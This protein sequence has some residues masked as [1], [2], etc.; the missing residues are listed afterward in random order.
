MISIIIPVYNRHD[1][2]LVA[3]N[4]IANQTYTDIEVILVDDGSSPPLKLDASQ[5]PFSCT[6]L[7]QKN[8]GAPV[9][10]N[11]GFEASAGD[12]V[13]FWDA[14]MI[15]EPHMLET[16]YAKLQAHRDAAYTYSNF[17]WGRKKMRARPF[18]AE[19][20]MQT[21]FITIASLI[22]RDA[23]V[24]FDESLKK[25]QDWDLW[26]TMLERGAVGAWIDAYLFRFE[27]GG[28]M[29]EWLPKIAYRRPWKFLPGIRSIVQK[30]ETARDIIYKKH[31]I[32]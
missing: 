12:F 32:A 13:I 24:P 14:D 23:V 11:A 2:L 19:A 8:Q 4:S 26:L 9:A 10:R 22:R 30:Y 20:L 6:V 25:F 3:L 17:Y 31:K 21:N 27:T 18:D 15:G 29:S 5:Y 7:V 16:M 28:T 1:V